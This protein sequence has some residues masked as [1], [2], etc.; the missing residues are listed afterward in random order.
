M[1][2][3][4]S[5]G[6]ESSNQNLLLP[7]KASNSNNGLYLIVCL[8]KEFHRSCQTTHILRMF[9]PYVNAIGCSSQTDGKAPLLKSTSTQL[10]EHGEVKLVSKYSL[11]PMG[12]SSR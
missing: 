11:Y 5:R 12:S 4:N 1:K 2:L 3:P 7:Y 10:M 9:Y 8:V 6:I